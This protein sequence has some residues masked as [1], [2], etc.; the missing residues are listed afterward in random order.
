[1]KKTIVAIALAG[2]F[3]AGASEATW[4]WWLPSE[5]NVK[6]C[7]QGGTAKHRAYKWTCA[8]ENGVH[9]VVWDQTYAPDVE[10]PG[11]SLIFIAP[12]DNTHPLSDAMEEKVEEMCSEIL[13][14]GAVVIDRREIRPAYGDRFE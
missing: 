10:R 12:G 1:M 8:S 4:N 2:T 3:V 13:E 9:N 5:G 11:T 7:V 6:A 14:E